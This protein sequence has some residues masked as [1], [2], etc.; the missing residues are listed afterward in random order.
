[1]T[2]SRGRDTPWRKC[3]AL[4]QEATENVEV[5]VKLKVLTEVGENM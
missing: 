2:W 4:V 5:K 1:M 3:R